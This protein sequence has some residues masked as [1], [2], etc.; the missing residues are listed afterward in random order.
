MS[1]SHS[2]G[3]EALVYLARPVARDQA[4]Y[5]GLLKA[6]RGFH[7]PW[8][9]DRSDD[10]FEPAAFQAFL[11]SDTGERCL[12]HFIRRREDKAI[13]GAVNL[14][15]I[16]RGAF[17]SAYLGYWV[18]AEFAGRGYMKQALAQAIQFAFTEADLHRL[19]ANIMP[20]NAA[21]LAVVKSLG[22]Q[23]EGISPGYLKIAGQWRDHERWTILRES[24]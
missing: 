11:E 19:E 2:H 17:Q 13:V 16:V 10:A 8:F 7:D 15:E 22:F 5:L 21:S 9:P 23:R 20:E 18:G 12:R 4:D 3:A 14:N 6:S 1:H 24:P